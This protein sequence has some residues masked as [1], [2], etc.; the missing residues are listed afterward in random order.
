RPTG[1][2][3]HYVTTINGD[4]GIRT[5]GELACFN[6][7]QIPQ[8]GYKGHYTQLSV[9]NQAIYAIDDAGVLHAPS[10]ASFPEG[11][12]IFVSAN[13]GAAWGVR[14]DG[15]V[16][17]YAPG[18]TLLPPPDPVFVQVAMEYN[19]RTACGL[20]RDGTISCWAGQAG[21]YIYAPSPPDDRF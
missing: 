3:R 17:C 12:Y 21:N 5:T 10:F 19:S 1:T 7:T 13:N 2:F 18:S 8:S 16:S 11:K 20:R 15:A 4:C 14:E 9:A 6:G